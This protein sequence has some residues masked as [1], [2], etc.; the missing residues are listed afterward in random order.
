MATVVNLP[1]MIKARFCYFSG[2]GEFILCADGLLRTDWLQLSNTPR[3]RRDQ[4]MQDNKGTMPGMPGRA[5]IY[6]V[7]IVT[8]GSQRTQ[9]LVMP[10]TIV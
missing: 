1:R 6:Y 4:I 5:S 9:L 3:V 7:H 8:H 10:E 2:K